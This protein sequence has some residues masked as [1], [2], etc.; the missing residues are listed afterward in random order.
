LTFP[1]FGWGRHFSSDLPLNYRTGPWLAWLANFQQ[2]CPPPNEPFESNEF[3]PPPPGEPEGVTPSFFT[4]VHTGTRRGAPL[5]P[6]P[7]TG[8]P[9]VGGPR[10]GERLYMFFYPLI[11]GVQDPPKPQRVFPPFWGVLVE[12]PK[13]REDQTGLAK[14]RKHGQTLPSFS[15]PTT[16]QK[17]PL[18]RSNHPPPP[19]DLSG[20]GSDFN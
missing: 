10:G 1:L 12:C 8:G 17:G 6:R 2:A 11:V 14:L 3:S 9:P 15:F 16:C 13:P 7:V 5:E 18:M 19:D 4:W 20:S